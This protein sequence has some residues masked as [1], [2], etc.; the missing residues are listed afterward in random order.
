MPRP[1]TPTP[2]L[3]LNGAMAINPGRY[4][5]RMNEPSTEQAVGDPPDAFSDTKK[6]IWR[7]VV[8]MVAGGVLQASDR[9]ILEI[10]CHLVFELR[11]GSATTASI[12]Q[13][14]Q[15]LASLGMTPA[16][17]SR[18]SAMPAE[19]SHDPLAFLDT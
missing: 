3:Q 1:R 10:I 14:R 4:A 5:S 7:E 15:S 12:A 17:R 16:D 9:L 6:D 18:V 19:T 11:S 13:L 8:G 2:L